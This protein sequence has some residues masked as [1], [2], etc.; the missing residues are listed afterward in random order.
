MRQL[1]QAETDRILAGIQVELDKM[2]LEM[3]AIHERVTAQAAN[4]SLID[5][6][7][8]FGVVHNPS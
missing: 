7:T 2:V 1:D 4:K 8:G 6:V 5:R 3:R